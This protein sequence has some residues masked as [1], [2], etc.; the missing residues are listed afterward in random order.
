M[1]SKRPLACFTIVFCLGIIIA[2]FFRIDSAFLYS[3]ATI[4][5]LSCFVFIK[6]RIALPVL[7][8]LLAFLLGAVLWNN[9]A[10]LP[11]CHLSKLIGYKISLPYII[12]GTIASEPQLKNNKLSFFFKVQEIQIGNLR[13][14]CCGELLVYIMT[15]RPLCYAE[16]LTLAGNLYRPFKYKGRSPNRLYLMN[17]KRIIAYHG[18]NRGMGFSLMR[19][20]FYLKGRI[21]R[22]IFRYLPPVPAGILDAMTLGEKRSIPI[23]LYKSMI[24]SGTVHILVVSGFN[25]G[26]VA[27]IISLILKSIRIPRLWRF[28]IAVPLLLLY[29]LMTGAST[30][31]VRATVMSI[32]FM[33]A[34]FVK[35]KADIYN[36][37]AIAGLFILLF[38]PSQLFDIGFQLSFASVISIVYF[39]PRLKSFLG[40]ERLRIKFLR[41][42][43]EGCLVSLSAWLGT[44]GFI[45]YYFKIFSPITVIANL[46]IVPLATLITFCGFSLI[47]A[48]LISSGLTQ[49]FAPTSAFLAALLVRINLFLVKLPGAYM[50]L[51]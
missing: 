31:V 41:V 3:L 7:L 51:R 25:L 49:L 34:Y 29:C 36:T 44:A 5:A 37:S 2:S 27:F 46:F 16:K 48:G 40:L 12:K 13:Y 6:S 35:R 14:Y 22:I 19:F 8:L 17:A 42:L 43:A 15:N 23:M 47:F 20:A 39:Y 50:Y 28:F 30:P 21:E 9:Q 1:F 11:K 32:V 45:A 26:L 24:K 38:N 33:A 18:A 10:T 4:F